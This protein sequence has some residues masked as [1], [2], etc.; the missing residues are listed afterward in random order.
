MLHSCYLSHG[1]A[2]GAARSQIFRE[3]V[4]DAHH[5]IRGH[6]AERAQRAHDH[7]VAELAQQREVRLL[8]DTVEN[9]VDDLDAAHRTDSTR[10]ALTARLDRAEFHREARL[11]TE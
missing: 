4:Q 3:M 9:P 11:L 8:V 10:R 7:R 2:L 6:A 5:G 1:A